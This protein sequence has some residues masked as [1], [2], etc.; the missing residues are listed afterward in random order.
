LSNTAALGE[1]TTIPTIFA[2]GGGTRSAM[3]VYANSAGGTHTNNY[4]LGFMRTGTGS[5]HDAVVTGSSPSDDIGLNDKN[6]ESTGG[7]VFRTTTFWTG[8][9]FDTSKWNFAYLV[10][11]GYPFLKNAGGQ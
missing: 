11:K 5:T 3:R 9:G 7:A 6:G 1:G 4:A 10:S 8:L 2:A